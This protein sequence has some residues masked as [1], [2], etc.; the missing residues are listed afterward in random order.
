MAELQK[1]RIDKWLWAVRVFKTRT[2]ATN[3]CNAGRVK[4]NEVSVKA[5]RKLSVGETVHIRKGAMIIIYKV[6]RLI[7]K[8]QSATLVADCFID[9]SP[10][11][12]PKPTFSKKDAAFFD[13]PIAHRKR[14]EGRPAKRERR[15]IDELQ[16]LDPNQDFDEDL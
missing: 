2:L 11:P 6:E 9:Q 5:S 7:E 1:I 15:K 13:F 10:P 14:G 12:P 8:R 4:I 3:A 16:D